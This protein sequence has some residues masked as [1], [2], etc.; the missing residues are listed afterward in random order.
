MKPEQRFW[1]RLRPH[2]PG[3]V[4]RI[5]NGLG[6]GMPDVNACYQG[7]EAW[8]ELKV[9]IPGAGVLLR[10]EQYAWGR[11]RAVAGGKVFVICEAEDAGVVLCFAYPQ[12]LVSPYG[13]SEKYVSIDDATKAGTSTLHT[14]SQIKGNS[15]AKILFP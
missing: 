11:G 7:K 14:W 13:R 8:I 3:H 15:L 1:Q 4:F 2:V 6:A 5:E 12:F 9:W 10:K